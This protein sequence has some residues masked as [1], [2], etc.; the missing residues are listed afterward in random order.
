M[1]AVRDE[2]KLPLIK[3]GTERFSVPRPSSEAF[4][5]YNKTTVGYPSLPADRVVMCRG[6]RPE[7][8][9]TKKSE[10]SQADFVRCDY[11]LAVLRGIL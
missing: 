9:K 2:E 6:L 8:P 3:R 4:A 7:L 5:A 1:I 11:E 10:N